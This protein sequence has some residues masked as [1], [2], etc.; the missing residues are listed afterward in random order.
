MAA[1]AV[2]VEGLGLLAAGAA[3]LVQTLRSTPD[4]YGRAG[5]AV[6]MAVLGGLLMLRLALGL[7]RLE[8]WVRAPVIVAQV[9][10]WPVGYTLAVQAGLPWYG[11]PILLLAAAAVLALLSR[12][13]RMAFRDR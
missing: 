7:V 3:L 6:V 12:P 2:A 5:F 13:A 10:L 1:A 11:V 4:S 8:G 9:L